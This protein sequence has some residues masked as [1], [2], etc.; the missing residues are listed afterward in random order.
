VFQSNFSFS[1][2]SNPPYD[3][4]AASVEE[5]RSGAA[6]MAKRLT[7]ARDAMP[8]TPMPRQSERET[9][10]VVIVDMYFIL[11]RFS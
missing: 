4:A 8:S 6:S 2:K 9:V 5:L 11:V 1:G 7:I 10:D 3:H